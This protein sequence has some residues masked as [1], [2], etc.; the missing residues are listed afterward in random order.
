MKGLRWYTSEIAVFP[1]PPFPTNFYQNKKLLG[2]FTNL[3]SPNPLTPTSDQHETS[4]YNILT[5]SNK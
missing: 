5:L 4:P 3:H 2:N 1:Y